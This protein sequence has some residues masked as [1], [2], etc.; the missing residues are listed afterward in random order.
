MLV[1]AFNQEKA[2]VGREGPSN[3][4][5]G[6]GTDGLI[7]GTSDDSGVWEPG[8]QV[9]AIVSAPF[10]VTRISNWVDSTARF[11]PRFSRRGCTLDTQ[12][13]RVCTCGHW[14]MELEVCNGMEVDFISLLPQLC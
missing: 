6:C 2:L 10:I 13:S 12:E 8:D 3:V 7:C 14:T 1:G 4:K 11:I 9:D 5:T